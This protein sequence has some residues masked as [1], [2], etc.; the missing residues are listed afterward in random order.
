MT[1][2]DILEE[3]LERI[4]ICR[5]NILAEKSRSFALKLDK[6][7]RKRPPSSASSSFKSN[8]GSRTSPHDLTA[9]DRRL[10][11]KNILKSTSIFGTVPK[12][13]SGSNTGS[14]FSDGGAGAGNRE[15]HNSEISPNDLTA[16]VIFDECRTGE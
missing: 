8:D 7:R 15:H 13:F 12:N 16:S 5:K 3:C 11:G 14:S 1:S 9:E 6:K 10:G 4:Y 2:L